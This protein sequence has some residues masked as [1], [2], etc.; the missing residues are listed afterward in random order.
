MRFFLFFVSLLLLS[1]SESQGDELQPP[2]KVRII[3]AEQQIDR[4]PRLS[5]LHPWPEDLG[6]A[7]AELGI[8][9]NQTTGKFLNQSFELEEVI[10]RPGEHLSAVIGPKLQ[11]GADLIIANA[12]A[13]ELLAM[14]DLPA[15]K[16][17]IIFNAAAR[18]ENL[19]EELCRSN[20]LHTLPTRSMLTDAL[21]Q[22]F[23]KKQWTKWLLIAGDSNDDIAYANALR[24]SAKKFGLIIVGEKNWVTDSDL[25]EN[26]A[27][28]VPL[29]TQDTDYDAILVADENDDFGPSIAL[30]S[31]LPRPVAGTH[32]LVATSWSD[33]IEPWGAIQ[34]QN[35]FHDVS[36]R[37]MRDVDF[38]AYVAVRIIGEAATRTGKT[39][40]A[41]LRKFI[42]SDALQMSAFKGRG[43]TFRPWNGQLRQPI[44]LVTSDAQVAVAPLEGFLHQVNDLDTLGVDQPETKCVKF[45]SGD[46]Q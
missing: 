34:L 43:L 29:M 33:V 6:L 18:D 17:T 12:P 19:R 1:A 36:P 10:A 24:N 27:T 31:W 41:A 15:A 37:P 40:V 4:P 3:Y 25:R 16:N 23:I 9:D 42:L 22:F 14:A 46:Q 2:V 5:G 35:R 26:A 11:S 39:D 13:A 28:E 30:N 20:V 8:Q 45:M 7:G 32:G 21:A 38:A 44:H